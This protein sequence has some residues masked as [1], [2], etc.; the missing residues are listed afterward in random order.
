VVGSVSKKTLVEPFEKRK[1]V[2]KLCWGMNGERRI[3]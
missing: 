1:V 2:G 3:I